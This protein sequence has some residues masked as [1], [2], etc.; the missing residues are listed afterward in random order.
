MVMNFRLMPE[1]TLTSIERGRMALWA[2]SLL[3]ARQER[4][5]LWR[6]MRILY[7]QS[8]CMLCNVLSKDVADGLLAALPVSI[9]LR[10]MVLLAF[11]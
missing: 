7:V 10:K 5:A 9:S 8:I 2:E 1:A 11:I 6:V 3:E 4:W